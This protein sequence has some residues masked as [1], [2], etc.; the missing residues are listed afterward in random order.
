M[1]YRRFGNV[2]V[3]RIDKGE[4][5]VA[6]L[7]EI[8][9][10]EGVKLAGVSALGAVNDF[11]VGLYNTAERKYDFTNFTG[12]HEI[13]GLTGT[14]NTMDGEYYSHLHLSASGEG[15]KVVGGHLARAVVSIVCE[16]VINIID[17]QVD[18]KFNEE[19]GANLMSFEV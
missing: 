9:L 4:E 15:G 10:K 19:I 18:R 14:I 16:M 1:D 11:T 5:L 17:G 2:I 13:V 3:A 7:K 6:A 8:G 12:D